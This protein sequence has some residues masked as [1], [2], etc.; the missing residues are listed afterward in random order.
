MPRLVGWREAEFDLSD[1]LAP[2]QRAMFSNH[3]ARVKFE[4]VRRDG[5]DVAAHGS[6]TVLDWP[7]TFSAKANYSLLSR[8]ADGIA[9]AKIPGSDWRLSAKFSWSA[10]D[11]WTA[12]VHVPETRFDERDAAFGAFV[13][14]LAADAAVTNLAF[15]GM[16]FL[17]AEASATNAH[18]VA[19]WKASGLLSDFSAS[20]A[21][22]GTPFSIGGLR[23]RFGASG[24]DD[25]TDLAP[26]F[27]RAKSVEAAGVALSNVFA[28]VRAT[29]TAWL[30]TEAGADVCG[31][32]A[33]LY[34]LYLDPEK[35]SAG[36]TLYLDDID[37]G[38][39]LARLAG[40][41]GSATGRLHGKL[42]LRLKEGREV[43]FGNA[44]LYSAPGETGTLR[45]EN[46]ELLTDSLA[47]T[48]VDAATC[49]N[50]AKA[51]RNLDY[52]ALSL[53][54]RRGDG[55]HTLAVRLEGSATSGKTTVPVSLAV[56]LHGDMER[57]VNTGLRATGAT[58]TKGGKQR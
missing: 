43:S 57:L 27:P 33:R 16:V 44:Y 35:L 46:P 26:L 23:L 56:R 25:H 19:K 2:E 48:G 20:L 13:A 52:T 17:D 34:S 24:V 12:E 38:L 55:E 40:F 15:S 58:S 53:D 5:W 45:M 22:D 39:A 8:R 11:G 54:L 10:K 36:L 9:S 32:T 42:P 6:G 49:D 3:V 51:L 7:F 29:E 31:G 14:R 50:A 28:S 21:A 47:A 37:T 30:V 4:F 18:R 41:R 1:A